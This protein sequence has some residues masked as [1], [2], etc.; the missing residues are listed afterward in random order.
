MEYYFCISKH[1]FSRKIFSILDS[2]LSIIKLFSYNTTPIT[3]ICL[4]LTRHGF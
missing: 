1:Y 3:K 4:T 2:I